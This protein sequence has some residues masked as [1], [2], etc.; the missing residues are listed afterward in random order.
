MLYKLLAFNNKHRGNLEVCWD[1][2][3]TTKL[4]WD[5]Q[6]FDCGIKAAG[7]SIGSTSSSVSKSVEQVEDITSLSVQLKFN[8]SWV[9]Q[10]FGTWLGWDWVWQFKDDSDSSNETFPSHC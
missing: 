2:S 5:S 3:S 8:W 6:L 4:G 1:W 9:W 10:L 7:G